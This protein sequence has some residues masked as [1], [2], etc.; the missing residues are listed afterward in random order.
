[1]TTY[2]ALISYPT[3][4]NLN[5]D[6]MVNTF[7]FKEQPLI[8]PQQQDDAPQNIFER[9]RDFYLS[10]DGFYGI[11]VNNPFTVRVY[12]LA[13]EKPRMPKLVDTFAID[14]TG[15]LTSL[16]HEVALVGSYNAELG[17][18]VDPSHRRGRVY[19]GPISTAF[20]VQT[21]GQHFITDEN[22]QQLA[23]ALRD[24]LTVSTEQLI[25]CVY[26]ETWHLGRGATAG[27]PTKPPKPAIPPHT[28]DQA[29]FEV[30]RASV[31]NAFDTQRRR[32]N[33]AS[34][35]LSAN[36]AP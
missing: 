22:A 34:K 30:V 25:G 1:M 6:R 5:A 19:L 24:L 7:H 14:Q 36:A 18:G 11:T 23:D 15:A 26:S 35:R 32:G 13:D 28:L 16:P 10:I 17:S 29:S 31:D 2:R 33:K 8:T 4:S 12:D 20:L 3:D 9:V 21:G 27:G